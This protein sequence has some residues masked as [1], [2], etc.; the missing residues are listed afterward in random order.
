MAATPPPIPSAKSRQWI[1]LRVL[2]VFLGIG[3]IPL[4]ASLCWHGRLSGKV[5][6]RLNA[7]RAAG[8]P[9]TTTEWNR[10]YRDVPAESNAAVFYAQAFDLIQK[11]SSF[12]FL[13]RFDELPQDG[14]P[15]PEDLREQI[16]K[17][18][19]ENQIT[20]TLLDKAANLKA[21]RY[22]VDYTPGWN[23]LL[24]HL[25]RLP[26]CSKLQVCRGV[27]QEQ[28]GDLDGA[29]NSIGIILEYCRSLDSEP[30]VISVLVQHKLDFH[31]SEIL[32]WVLNHRPLSQQQL[33]TL[34]QI[35]APD[36]R[37]N[38]LDRA[39]IG[40]RCAALAMFDYPAADFLNLVTPGENRPLDR[41]GVYLLRLSGRTKQDCIS[42]LDKLDECR[43]AFRLPLPERLDRIEQIKSE[44]KQEGRSRYLF[45]TGGILPVFLKS[46]DRD[47][48]NLARRRLARTALA[49]EQC[50]ATQ[51]QLPDS[52]AELVPKYL[53]QLPPDP[54]DGKALR[55]RK[56][57]T[58]YVVYSV[59]PDRVDGGGLKPISRTQTMTDPRG[60]IIFAIT[61]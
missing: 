6:S 2:F 42:F 33:T 51:G 55:Y 36:E 22:P 58:G 34:Q 19:T 24:P 27:L 11:N 43:D 15:L 53:P 25:R 47:A 13:E 52:V 10:Y 61:R 8:E 16:E 60:D 12:S 21:C 28:K 4:T 50:R 29:I 44:A 40:D 46:F 23:A 5:S 7:I 48:Q 20:F 30:D 9:V 17:A 56:Q 54:F 3:L 14:N 18:V 35:Y 38:W 1:G 49:I 57:V 31:A 45:V 39:L 37:T 32:R 59:G 41:L 26:E